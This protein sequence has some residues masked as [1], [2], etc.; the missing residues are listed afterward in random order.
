MFVLGTGVLGV[1]AAI[2]LGKQAEKAVAEN[3]I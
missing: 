1:I 3:A 2:I